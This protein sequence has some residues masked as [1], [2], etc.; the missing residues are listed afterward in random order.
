MSV[1][2]FFVYRL[3]PVIYSFMLRP[4]PWLCVPAYAI[5]CLLKS[6]GSFKTRLIKSCRPTDWHPVELED[7]QKYECVLNTTNM[8]HP[9]SALEYVENR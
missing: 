4:L 6:R 7:R 2:F 8:T 1:T 9:L 3:A 5:H